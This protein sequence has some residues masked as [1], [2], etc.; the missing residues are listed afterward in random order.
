MG[1]PCSFEIVEIS[2]DAV[3]WVGSPVD[4]G[5][6][7]ESSPKEVWPSSTL[8]KWSAQIYEMEIGVVSC[9]SESPD[10][11]RKEEEGEREEEMKTE[12]SDISLDYCEGTNPLRCCCPLMFPHQSYRMMRKMKK[13]FHCLR[14]EYN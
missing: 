6:A 1:V 4:V 7:R 11:V 5:V 13:M 3:W 2:D 8:L 9:T 10:N 14:M 12:G